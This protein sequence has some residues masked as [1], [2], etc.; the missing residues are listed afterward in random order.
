MLKSNKNIE[1]ISVSDAI[2]S[3]HST[4]QFLEQSIDANII[5][6]ILIKASRSPSGANTQPWEVA[7]VT[8]ATKLKLDKLLTEAF[9]NKI[10]ATPDY[11]YYPTNMPEKFIKRKTHCGSLLYNSVSI[12]YSD[13]ENRIKQWLKNYSAFNAP[14]VLYFFAP[15]LINS[16][17]FL[18]Y[19]MFLQSIM[20]L[21]IEYGL[22]TC[23]QAALAEYPNIIKQELS[24][25]SDDYI[26]LCGMAIGYEDKSATINQYRTPREDL[27]NFTKYFT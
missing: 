3:R 17:S 20:L 14:V 4:R 1:S 22:S 10:P 21:A 7:V 23:A 11:L 26:L 16:G 19:G 9:I 13:K 18:D 15:K 25:N 12:D 24:Y 5:N 8:G 6:E 2:C 27:Q